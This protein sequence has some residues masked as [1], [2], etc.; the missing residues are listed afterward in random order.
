[1]KAWS[2]FFQDS[3][4]FLAI[5]ILAI[6][7]KF[8]IFI[9]AVVHAPQGKILPDSPTYL[10]LANTLA[11]IGVFAAQGDNGALIFAYGWTRL[12][13]YIAILFVRKRNN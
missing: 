6:A 12:S 8:F 13:S 2:K 11:S 7:I 4:Y 3:C 1:M 9:F 5:V 10:R